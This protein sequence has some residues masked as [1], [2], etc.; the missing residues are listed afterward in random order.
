MYIYIHIYVYMM[1]YHHIN[2][3]GERGGVWGPLIVIIH[4]NF[5]EF[6][7]THVILPPGAC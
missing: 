5:W 4:G 2:G 6:V 7:R 3:S 1:R